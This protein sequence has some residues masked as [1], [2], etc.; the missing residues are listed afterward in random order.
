[1]STARTM[2]RDTA[3]KIIANM[4]L[5]I[6][7]VLNVLVRET[8]CVVFLRK[9][10]L[11]GSRVGICEGEKKRWSVYFF[12]LLHKFGST[13]ELSIGETIYAHR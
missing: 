13:T 2:E 6:I 12:Y 5:I 11:E 1:M 3:R 9:M 10:V 4:F 7:F 8:V